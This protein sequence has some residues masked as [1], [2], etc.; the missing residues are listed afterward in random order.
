MPRKLLVALGAAVALGLVALLYFL[1]LPE[2]FD[3]CDNQ[4]MDISASVL[5]DED[6]QSGMVNRAIFRRGSCDPNQ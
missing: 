1:T 5:S 3:E 6:E 2:S 4:Q